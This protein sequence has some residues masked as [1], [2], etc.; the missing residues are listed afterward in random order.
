MKKLLILLLALPLLL[1]A[2][3]SNKKKAFIMAQ[4]GGGS[5]S[6]HVPSNY[7]DLIHDNI[8]VAGA[9]GGGTLSNQQ[10]DSNIT[11][12]I[13]FTCVPNGSGEITVTLANNATGVNY[14]NALELSW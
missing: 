12:T 8:T 9:S 11:N 14:L 2:Q 4:G 7:V 1:N 5:P 13:D 10:T 6:P 3:I